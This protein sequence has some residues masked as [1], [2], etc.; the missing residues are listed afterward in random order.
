MNATKLAVIG[1]GTN[2]GARLDLIRQARELLERAPRTR[3][4]RVAKIYETKA[5]GPTQPDYLNTAW[6]VETELTAPELFSELMRIEQSL[7]RAPRSET[8]RW[9]AR[10]MDLDLLWYAGE[11]I[12]MPNLS[13]PHPELTKRSFALAPLLEVLPQLQEEYGRYLQA[14]GGAPQTVVA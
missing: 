13:V 7:G 6:C 10:T 2:L 8:T 12:Q 11:K 1:V 4:I 3:V 9:Q 5:I 14:L